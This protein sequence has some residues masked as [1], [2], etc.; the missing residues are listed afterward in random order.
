MK[1]KQNMDG[2]RVKGK[3]SLAQWHLDAFELFNDQ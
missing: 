1:T 3:K 2:M